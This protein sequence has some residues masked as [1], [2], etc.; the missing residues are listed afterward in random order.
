[1][2]IQCVKF[3]FG[4]QVN[5]GDKQFDLV[6]IQLYSCLPTSG[7]SSVRILLAYVILG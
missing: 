7:T 4:P 2:C 1:M 6:Y 5:G 3:V